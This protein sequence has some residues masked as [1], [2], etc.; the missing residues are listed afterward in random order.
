MNDSEK[1]AMIRDAMPATA[2][3]AYF[4]AG[5]V[6]PI[7]TIT[8]N[9]IQE[10]N[11]AELSEGRANMAAFMR[12]KQTTND[13]RALMAQ[14]VNAGL[15]EITI[16]HNTTDG[17]NIAA[18]GLNWQPGDEI[19]TTKLEHPGGLL[20][21][22][23]LRERFGVVVK[24]IDIPADISPDEVID[25]FE[26]AITPRTRLLAFSHV[27][28]NTGMC[29]PLTGIVAMA[30]RH[31]VLSAVD[32]AQGAGAV[33]LDLPATGVDFYALPGQKWLCGPEGIGA[34]YVRRES[35][36]LLR[37]TFVGYRSMDPDGGHDWAGYYTP[38]KDARRFEAATVYRPAIKGMVAN[39]NW[40]QETVGWGWIYARIAHLAE[41]A[42]R[43]LS[44]LPGVTVIT[45]PGPQAGLI[46]FNVDGYDP[47]RVMTKLGEEGIVLRFVPTPHALRI[48]TGFYNSEADI[49]RLV[50]GLQAIQKIDP[51]LLP[52]YEW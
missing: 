15:D 3:L 14:L 10:G 52:E 22:Y 43:A 21:F 11:T 9:A 24:I 44:A 20:P 33:P 34:L 30:H 6:G 51:E 42:H 26:A 38:Q 45:P 17:M 8:V 41:Y 16:T 25:R 12:S 37:P 27:A 46:T 31:H 36:S 5:S 1:L 32:G 2:K 40:L 28:W 47:P 50:A 35:L 13:L 48:S 29:L 23:V 4:N 19:I 7:A 39:L 18:H 49:D